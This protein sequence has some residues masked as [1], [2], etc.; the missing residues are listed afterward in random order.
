MEC[1]LAKTPSGLLLPVDEDS[2]QKIDK[3]KKNQIIHVKYRI[4]RNYEN[5]KKFFAFLKATFDMQEHF[6]TFEHYRKWLIM[7]AG[8]YDAIVTPQNK[9]V[10]VA[11]SI[12]FDQMEEDD[13]EKLFSTCIDVFL[14]ELG[15][16]MTRDDVLRVIDFS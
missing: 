1:F 9:T 2:K 5:H 14:Q 12:S 13:F 7:K 10:F 3:L 15:K 4:P 16:G 8:W 6:D 11:K